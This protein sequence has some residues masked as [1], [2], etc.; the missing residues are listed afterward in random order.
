MTLVR[1]GMIYI[2]FSSVETV[3]CEGGCYAERFIRA[4]KINFDEEELFQKNYAAYQK[5]TAF[6]IL[7]TRWVLIVLKK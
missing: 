2:R 6:K 5:V 3:Y 1:G 7:S 4:R